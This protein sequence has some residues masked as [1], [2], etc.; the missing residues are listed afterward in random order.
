MWL[1]WIEQVFSK[2]ERIVI[3]ELILVQ[4]GENRQKHKGEKRVITI[5]AFKF[6]HEVVLLVLR[7]GYEIKNQAK[8][9]NI[10]E[11]REFIL[12]KSNC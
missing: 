11:D 10:E 12:V 2:C 7:P 1:Y 4:L 9:Q 3:I 8:I 5:L 6:F